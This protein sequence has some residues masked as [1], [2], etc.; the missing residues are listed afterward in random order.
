MQHVN[1]C[2]LADAPRAPKSAQRKKRKRYDETLVP[3]NMCNKCGRPKETT[4]NNLC[5][6]CLTYRG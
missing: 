2:R 3:I 6:P 1:H 4:V 5:F